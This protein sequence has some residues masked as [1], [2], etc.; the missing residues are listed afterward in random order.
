MAERHS[1]LDFPRGFFLAFRGGRLL[2]H[3]PRL[4]KYV[5]VPFLINVT[6]FSL[7]IF[8]GLRFFQDVVA[9][10]LPQG[11]AW[12]WAIVYYALWTVAV[13][14]T[15]VLVFFTFTVVGNLIASPFNELLS[16]RTEDLLLGRSA[17][18]PF[19]LGVFFRDMG[20]AW[21]VEIRKM[22]FFV[23]AM[24]A[25]LLL[26]LLPLVGSLLYGFFSVL[27]T[28]FFLAWEYLG[29]VHERKRRSFPEQRQYLMRRKG[30]VLGFAAGVLLMLAI[31]FLQL[32]CIPVA[33]VGA[34]LLWCEESVGHSLQPTDQ[35]GARPQGSS[36]LPG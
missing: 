14:V 5:I 36:D 33:V 26:N 35:T 20:R 1:L 34:T 21:L 4:F 10:L 17:E 31:P 11:E 29:F 13:L 25:L 3:H 12:Y 15:L 8:L 6:V 18:E 23:L 27:L 22:S 19:A 16:E 9:Q 24:A 2:L 30:L 28:L 7:S 32:F